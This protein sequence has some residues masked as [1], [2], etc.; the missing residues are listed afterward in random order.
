[1]VRQVPKATGSVSHDVG[2]SGNVIVLGDITKMPLMQSI[3][4]Q[5]KEARLLP[6]TQTGCYTT[7]GATWVS[8][9]LWAKVPAT[10][11]SEIDRLP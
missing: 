6:V 9:R 8:T 10:S 5:E 7:S 4:A 3:K 11:K 1:M 2:W